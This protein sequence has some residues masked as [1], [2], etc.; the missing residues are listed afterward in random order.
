MQITELENYSLITP[1]ENDLTSF[2]SEYKTK[3]DTLK[4]KHIIIDFLKSFPITAED[5]SI[6]S[7]ISTT[8]KEEGNSFVLIT[9]AVEI[10]DI[11]DETLSVVPT[12]V[13]A[14][15]ILEMD[16]IERDLGF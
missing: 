14:N 3:T 10:D 9:N 7:D 11:E 1:T 8:K 16:A 15:D 4:G 6:F 2:L 13:E 5:L 12:L